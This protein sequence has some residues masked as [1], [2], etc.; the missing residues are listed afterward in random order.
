ML[1]DIPISYEAEIVL[2]KN[3][4][5]HK[6]LF[7]KLAKELELELEKLVSPSKLIEIK[8]SLASEK[9]NSSFAK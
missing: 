2:K 6:E 3:P 1:I 8:K 5:I 9:R 7:K 4:D